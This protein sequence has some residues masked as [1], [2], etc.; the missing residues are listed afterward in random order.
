MHDITAPFVNIGVKPSIAI[1]REQGMGGHTEMA[2]AFDRAGFAAIDVHIN[3]IKNNLFS[4]SSVKAL[5]VCAGFSYGDTLGAGLGFA[6]RI[7]FD[8][9]LR[10]E[11]L[12]FFNRTDTFSLG[13]CNGCQ[14]LSALKSLIPGAELWPN[15]MPNHSEQFECR[16][17]MVQVEASPSILFEG[18][19]GSRLLVSIAHREGRAEFLNEEIQKKVIQQ[20]LVTLRFVD[21]RGRK[22]KV[23]PANPNGSPLGITGLT[24]EDGRVTILMPNPERAFRTVQYSWR[25]KDWGE[26]GPWLRI[27]RNG[28]VW[29]G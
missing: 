13:V 23:Y 21:S 5:A 14:T 25:P 3:D 9:Q 20:G 17:S 8:P 15:F 26:E 27:F 10:D 1:L 16:L 12:I 7:L 19:E 28:R 6:K 4:L 2:A 11:F 29:L 22:T 18:M 24:S